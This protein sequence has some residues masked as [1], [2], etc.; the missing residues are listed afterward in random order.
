MDEELESL[1]LK[2]NKLRDKVTFA[3]QDQ[4]MVE[5][6]EPT[7]PMN[8]SPDI[9]ESKSQDSVKQTCSKEAEEVA[10]LQVDAFDEK[11][12]DSLKPSP[13]IS[14]DY[15][16]CSTPSKSGT[17]DFKPQL[18]SNLINGANL[19]AV[20]MSPATNTKTS[21]KRVRDY[22]QSLPSPQQQSRRGD[23]NSDSFP[24]ELKNNLSMTEEGD[25]SSMCSGSQ[26]LV[27]RQSDLTSLTGSRM[28]SGMFYGAGAGPTMCTFPEEWNQI[29]P[30]SI[31]NDEDID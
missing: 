27:S 20:T 17:K 14:T 6:S 9:E 8:T 18:N 29:I 25:N 26:S 7:V 30:E 12:A 4:V 23:I 19:E 1:Q 13:N 22:I 3:Q 5:V 16:E 21:L 24:S 31:E 10:M 15:E 2:D 11:E 28:G